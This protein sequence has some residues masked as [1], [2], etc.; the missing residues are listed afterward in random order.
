M[1]DDITTLVIMRLFCIP[2]MSMNTPEEE[3]SLSSLLDMVTVLMVKSVVKVPSKVKIEAAFNL[4]PDSKFKELR[5]HALVIDPE[6][7][8]TSL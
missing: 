4:E 7:N 6:S 1:V 2:L 3:G 8:T 5:V